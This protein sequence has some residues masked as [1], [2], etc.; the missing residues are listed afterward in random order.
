MTDQQLFEL[1]Q[2][3]SDLYLIRKLINEGAGVRQRLLD[4][5]QCERIQGIADEAN[6]LIGNVLMLIDNHKLR[7][8]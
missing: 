8:K 7:S 3:Y 4:Q 2:L 5:S 6:S 1:G